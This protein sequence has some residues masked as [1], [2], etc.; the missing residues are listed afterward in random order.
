[1]ADF[2]DTAFDRGALDKVIGTWE[3]FRK[4]GREDLAFLKKL[5]S[6]DRCSFGICSERYIDR[7]G[8]PHD[9]WLALYHEGLHISR[10]GLTWR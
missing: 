2:P 4:Y 10:R 9:C 5:L 7:A 8:N 3:D 1:M 6:E